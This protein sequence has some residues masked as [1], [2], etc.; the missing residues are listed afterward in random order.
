MILFI[1]S[2]LLVTFAL[3]ACL[4]PKSPWDSGGILDR[5]GTMPYLLWA[6]GWALL[7]LLK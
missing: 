2:A 4:Q 5:L 3:V 7:A 6:V 1:L